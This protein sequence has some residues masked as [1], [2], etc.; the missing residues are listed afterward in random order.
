MFLGWQSSLAR[1]GGCARNI[2]TNSAASRAVVHLSRFRRLSGRAQGR[3]GFIGLGNMGEK[4]ARL[5][6]NHHN[7]YLVVVTERRGRGVGV[8]PPMNRASA[9]ILQF[10]LRFSLWRHMLQKALL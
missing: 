6:T 3:V 10:N 2:S 5:V 1:T 4:V 7:T 8:Q 9:I